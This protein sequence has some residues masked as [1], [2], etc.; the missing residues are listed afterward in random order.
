MMKWACESTEKY[1]K[2]IRPE[3]RKLKNK[4][5]LQKIEQTKIK[6]TRALLVKEKQI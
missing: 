4:T 2:T 3:T 1:F 6:E 5:R